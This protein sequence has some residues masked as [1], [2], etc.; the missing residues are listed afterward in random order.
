MII[1]GGTSSL[2]LSLHRIAES[3]NMYQGGVR[4]K[5]N[6]NISIEESL[7]AKL[8]QMAEDEGRS[9]SNMIEYLLRQAIAI[10]EK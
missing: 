7:L 1:K 10:K 9:L 6:Q 4:M 2:F 5:T 3:A 8:R